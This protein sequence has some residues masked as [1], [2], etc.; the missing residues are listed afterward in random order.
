MGGR[1]VGLDSQS[2][3]RGAD[4]SWFGI[5][6]HDALSYMITWQADARLIRRPEIILMIQMTTRMSF[7][8]PK[9]SPISGPKMLQE[10]HHS[11]Q[12]V[13]KRGAH[14][15]GSKNE[16]VFWAHNR[17]HAKKPYVESMI[18]QSFL[19]HAGPNSA[20]VFRPPFFL[21]NTPSGLEKCQL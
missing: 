16:P 5:S 12:K 19:D 15:S 13:N 3:V 1:L 6:R 10:S 17:V 2:P 11:F 8:I 14:F 21:Q 20:P 7:F 9:L 18:L 4:G